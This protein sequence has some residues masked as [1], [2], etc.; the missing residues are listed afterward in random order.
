MFR[1]LVECYDMVGLRIL[2]GYVAIHPDN[3]IVPGRTL[4]E[5]ADSLI[6]KCKQQGIEESLIKAIIDD[7]PN[8][9]ASKDLDHTVMSGVKS[10]FDLLPP[11]SLE[12][13]QELKSRQSSAPSG[14]IIICFTDIE[15][16]SSLSQT[17]DER[18]VHDLVG[19][20]NA[21]I[22][23]RINQH[24]GYEVKT[25]GDGFMIAFSSAADGVLCALNIQCGI[26]LWNASR[27]YQSLR[28]RIGLH[29]GQVISEGND[30]AGDT[31]NAAARIGAHAKGGQILVSETVKVLS[32]GKIAVNFTDYG[33]HPLKGFKETYHLYMLGGLC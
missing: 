5:A 14:I 12:E 21:I 16:F 20:H 4:D 11:V 18:A 1:A 32:E 28:V 6:R 7:R 19:Q 2:C 33:S 3:V 31:V 15:G 26:A 13:R 27:P 24:N 29:A 22:R 9:P 8:C 10:T 23:Q 17:M 30:F 25:M